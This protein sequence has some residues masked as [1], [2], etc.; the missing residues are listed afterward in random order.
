L[1]KIVE[2]KGRVFFLVN[3]KEAKKTLFIHARAG[4]RRTGIR[5][6][7]RM[8]THYSA[9]ARLL[10]WLIAAFVIGLLIAGW[11]L[12]FDLAPDSARH[13]ISWLHYSAGL[14][15][16]ALM[17]ARLATR[18]A[19]KPP[20]LPA[21]IPPLEKQL[22]RASHVLFYLLLFAMPVFGIIFVQA[23]GH[24]ISWFG[25]FTLPQL[26]PKDRPLSHLFSLL[27]LLG[28]IALTAL[29]AAHVAA[30][31]RHHRQGVPILRRMWG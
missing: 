27:H 14:T 8:E 15:I 28:G 21:A 19:N 5:Y 13:L 17:A 30:T 11:I 31:I 23:H 16:L 2:E 1:R 9:A 10:H 4:G 22:A 24:P 29:L 7:R 3:K 18:L 26:V 25:L 6:I 20:A 12:H